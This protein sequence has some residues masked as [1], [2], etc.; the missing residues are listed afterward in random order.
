MAVPEGVHQ[1]NRIKHLNWL[2]RKNLPIHSNSLF[3]DWLTG[4]L[5]QGNVRFLPKA[6]R[7][8]RRGSVQNRHFQ[9]RASILLAQCLL[10]EWSADA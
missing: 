1:S 9:S 8:W 2:T 3:R 4:T 7:L 6:D 10:G 5:G